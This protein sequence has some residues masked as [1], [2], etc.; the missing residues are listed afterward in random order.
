ML[1]SNKIKYHGISVRI[2]PSA[3][4]MWDEDLRPGR[5]ADSNNPGVLGDENLS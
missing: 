1:L 3:M 4:F 5:S 2:K